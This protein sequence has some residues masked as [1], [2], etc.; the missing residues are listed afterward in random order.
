MNEKND[1]RGNNTQITDIPYGRHPVFS[2]LLN[3]KLLDSNKHLQIQ[4]F[5]NFFVFIQ[6]KFLL[7]SWIL[8]YF[9][10]NKYLKSLEIIISFYSIN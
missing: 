7:F 4:F 9:Y 6:P 10:D 1:E 2:F 5:Q 8:K 3:E